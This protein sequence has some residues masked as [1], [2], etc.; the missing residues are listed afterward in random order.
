MNDIE[1][2]S[3][4]SMWACACWCVHCACNHLCTDI[5]YNDARVVYMHYI[6]QMY[7]DWMQRFGNM[8]VK[9]RIANYGN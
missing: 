5:L 9:V 2:Y 7:V 6:P 1:N 8:Q 4:V 3:P